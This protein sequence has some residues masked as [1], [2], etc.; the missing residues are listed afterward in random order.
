MSTS[1]LM[2]LM[3]MKNR[4]AVI[5]GATGHLGKEFSATLAEMGC[6]LCL[7]DR[8][9]SALEQV[10]ERLRNNHQVQVF[11]Y[12]CDLENQTA[13]QKLLEQLKENHDRLNVL[14]NNAAFVGDSNIQ[15]WAVDFEEQSLYSWRRAMEVNVT[16][17]FHLSQ[18]LIKK[19][20]NSDTASI[21]NIGSIYGVNG[22]DWHL[23]DGVEMAN[24]AAYAVSKG[25]LTQFTRWLATTCAPEVRV[26][27][28][29]PG[30][31]I[32]DQDDAFIERYEARTP[33]ARMAKEADF[34]GALAYLASD[35]SRYVTGQNLIVD[36]G[37]TV[38]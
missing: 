26:N 31:I 8:D 2:N 21:I 14:V 28:I 9:I 16:A 18:G 5:T 32:R 23:Y 11:S 6:D 27:M 37:W 1:M 30:G 13:R 34:S 38:W 12:G 36:G 20:A 33:M 24:P 35:M 17:A 7:V 22:P 29:S 25:G 15:G 10:A 4:V 19:M 3:D